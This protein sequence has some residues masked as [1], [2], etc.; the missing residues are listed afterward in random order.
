MIK[1]FTYNDGDLIETCSNC[2]G[3]SMCPFCGIDKI[4]TNLHSYNDREIWLKGFCEECGGDWFLIGVLEKSSRFD[5]ELVNYRKKLDKIASM[6]GNPDSG[7]A[8]RL[9]IEEINSILKK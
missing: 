6:C 7:E 5:I 1:L 3:Y 9:I 4:S 8:C 2:Q